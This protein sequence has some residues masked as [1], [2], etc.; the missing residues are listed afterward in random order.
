VSGERGG[1]ASPE[2]PRSIE[3]DL[4]AL[5]HNYR[6]L[7]AQVGPDIHIIP[8]L[9]ANA[10]GHGAGAVARSLATCD[11]HS[12]ATGSLEDAEAIQAG[13]PKHP[14]LL[15]GGTLPAGIPLLLERGF[16]PTVF[17]TEGAQAAAAWGTGR[18]RVFV[19]V[20]GGHGRLGVQM[21][22]ALDFIGQLMKLDGLEV[23]GVY[24]HVAF[25]DAEGREWVRKRLEAFN[26]L[27]ESLTRA[28]IEIPITQALS[29]STLAGG[30]T[31]NANAVSPG[32]LLWGIS[33]V[34]ADLVD[35][36]SYRPVLRSIRSRLIHIGTRKGVPWVGV[37]PLGLIDGYRDQV[38]GQR[39]EA[40]V[41]G[42]RVPIRS[43]SLE[44]ISLDLDGT[45]GL[46]VGDEV[47]LLGRSGDEEITID[48]LSRWAATRPT[49]ILMSLSGRMPYSYVEAR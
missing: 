8:A 39:A 14:V 11:I 6:A 5:L 9:K 7:R 29:S 3:I 15:F 30:L 28:G 37:I 2:R 33:A 12:M 10:Y 18:S 20:E 32:S 22:E 26:V 13:D 34:Q 48:D 1:L 46:S 40:L 45:S 41:G 24:T 35:M 25:F 4:G 27:L 49:H 19:K 44:H 23:A 36:S 17:D 42:Q 38:P 21:D 31:S 43:I 47:V 16:I